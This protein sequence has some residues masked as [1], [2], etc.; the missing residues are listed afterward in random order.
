MNEFYYGASFILLLSIG[1]TA[2]MTDVSSGKIY[3]R[4]LLKFLLIILLVDIA[5]VVIAKQDFKTVLLFF[6][7]FL[8]GTVIA[9]LLYNWGLWAAGDAKLFS[10][11]LLIIPRAIYPDGA[12]NIFPGFWLLVSVFSLGFLFVLSETIY[13]LLK[14]LRQ[15]RFQAFKRQ[16]PK[17][18]E[19]VPK[20]I[21]AFMLTLVV[22]RFLTSQFPTEFLVSNLWLTYFVSI[23]TVLFVLKH[24]KGARVY[25][26]LA[27][28]GGCL[29]L[30]FQG[31]TPWLN[32]KQLAGTILTAIAIVFIRSVGSL[33][34]YKEIPTNQ[35]SVGNILSF[36]TV[37][38]FQRSKVN[39]LPCFTDETTKSR[40]SND[41]VQ[42]IK[43]W[44]T[45]KYGSDKIRI[46]RH[47]PFAPYIFLGSL[48][49]FLRHFV[50]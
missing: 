28:L 37:L 8:L 5:H 18:K 1:L 3:N 30:A 11:V 43:R 35:V 44:Q 16:F 14:D 36:D 2:S 34:N 20:Y 4:H 48:L 13:F 25:I 39:G 7:N 17:G 19:I 6:T 49:V 22:N 41:E 42:S 27:I 38:S 9:I 40:L 12:N 10:L 15:G 50:I 23:M 33:Y 46:V 26:F 32:Y 29:L 24:I 31:N 45:S 47:L 21:F